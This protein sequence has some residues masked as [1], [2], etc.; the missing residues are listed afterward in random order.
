MNIDFSKLHIHIVV[1][2]L[3][4]FLGSHNIFAE[5]FSPKNSGLKP[6]FNRNKVIAHRGAWKN[7][8]TPE[9]SIASLKAAILLGCAG[10]ETDV[11]MTKDGALVINHDPV[12]AG[13]PVQKT[14]LDELRKMKLSNGE[15][16]PLLQDFLKVIKEQSGT[17]LFL[18]IKPSENGPEWARETV[19]KVVRLVQKKHAEKWVEYIS[20]DYQMLKEIQKLQPSAAVHYLNGDRSPVEL[21]KDGITGA[22][23]HFS[24]FQSHPDWI[25]SARDNNIVLNAWTV[26]D[27]K[28]MSWL[29]ANDFDFITT[30]EP[31]LLFKEIE[32]S[33]VANGMKLIWSDEFNYHGLPDS[34]KW[35]FDIG[36]HGWGNHEKQFY[37]NADTSNAIVNNGVLSIIARKEKRENSEFTSARL[38]TKGKA[39]WTYG[40]IEVRAKLPA[41]VGLWPAAW[42]LGSNA[43]K[44]GWPMCGEID[45]MEHVGYKKDS[46]FGT[47]HTEAYNHRKNTQK[48]TTVFINDPYNKF[49]RYSVNWTP[50]KIGF[51]LDGVKYYEFKNEHKTDAEWPFG[52]PFYILLNMAVGGDFGG[53]EGIDEGVFPA[54]YE[55]DYVRVFQ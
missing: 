50:E 51:F 11:H 20:F 4:L 33:P 35:N 29:L 17:K 7:T 54:V 26:N 52:K 40:L 3:V 38:L 22:D 1:I 10:S 42:M 2:S 36:G 13:M 49:H 24:V 32:R 25:K 19:R 9:N 15:S 6:N 34:A 46:V 44:V 53:K 37:T 14:A 43:E 31:E 27:E 55:I 8:G 41:G 18:E 48:G 45:I 28:T 5:N 39:Q 23:Y 47:V 21:K 12:W 16:L 30:N